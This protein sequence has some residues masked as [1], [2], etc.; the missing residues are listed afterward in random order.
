[1]QAYSIGW[2]FVHVGDLVGVLV[3]EP[4]REA[5][6]GGALATSGIAA[7][8]IVLLVASVMFALND[9]GKFLEWKLPLDGQRGDAGAGVLRHGH[10]RYELGA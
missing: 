7:V 1:M 10:A 3:A 8:L 6:S 5:I 4:L 9:E 2:L